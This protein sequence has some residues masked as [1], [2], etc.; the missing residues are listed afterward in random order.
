M[1]YIGSDHGGLELKEQ[2]K[3]WLDEWQMP[4]EDLGPHEMDPEDDYPDYAF[5]VS[6]K[7]A[8]DPDTNKGILA[9]RSAAG[10]IIAANKVTNVRAVSAFNTESAKHSREH[11][12]ANVLG[13]SG[14]WMTPEQAKEVLQ[15]WL[16]TDFPSEERHARRINK[17]TDY[18]NK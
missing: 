14:D 18:E 11:N 4:Y 13:L 17:I 3:Q 15:A 9:C 7:V 1:I 12:N 16:G 5:P 6:E 8:E 10:V 2:I